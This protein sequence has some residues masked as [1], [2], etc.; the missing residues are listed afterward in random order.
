VSI[1]R[2]AKSL[3]DLSAHRITIVNDCGLKFKFQYVDEIPA[4]YEGG[5]LLFGNVIHDGVAEWYGVGS[6]TTAN[7][8]NHQQRDLVELVNRQW[9]GR[10]PPK[11]WDLLV[12]MRG[13]EAECG[14]VAEAIQ[15]QRPE[16]KNPAQ[17]VQYGESVAAK[18]MAEAKEEMQRLCGH[19]NEIRWP[20]SEDP[21]Q[22]YKKAQLIATRLQREWR[23]QPRPLL[24]EEPFRLQFGNYVIRGRIDQVR[25][26]LDENG[27]LQ[28]PE[29]NDIKTGKDPLTQMQ[30]FWQSF[31]YWKANT[32]FDTTPDTT[33][34]GFTLARHVHK[35]GRTKVQEGHIDP[36]RHERLASTIL[37]GVARRIATAQFE[38]HYGYH[39]KLCDYRN[40][41]EKE[42]A[43]WEGEGFE[44][45]VVN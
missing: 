8:K 34:V 31:I 20:K 42:I 18:R 6:R 2:E 13:I 32:L 16:L 41:C 25:Q 29:V 30:A 43:L 40:R 22:A 36:E 33:R 5:S 24:V 7:E 19:S 4:P 39:C 38:P 23:E 26:D 1:D 9:E 28:E 37:N 21:W 14:A 12:E 3:T 15:M 27:E 11:I 35:D 44:I 45:E 17:T 10:L